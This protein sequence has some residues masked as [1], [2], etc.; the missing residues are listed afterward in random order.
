MNSI[1]SFIRH[2]L[3]E[4]D[5]NY[6]VDGTVQGGIVSSLKDD[7]TENT[8]DDAVSAGIIAAANT[9][10][11]EMRS[12]IINDVNNVL[13]TEGQV[14]RY[15]S[16]EDE[17]E[18]ARGPEF[19]LKA[20]IS[21]ITEGKFNYPYRTALYVIGHFN[22]E[23]SID[24]DL[25]K[26]EKEAATAAK[27]V[28]N[29]KVPSVKKG[30]TIDD[31]KNIPIKSPQNERRNHNQL[32]LLLE[33]PVGIALALLAGWR[34]IM[35]H[36]AA[37]A[38]GAG[39]AKATKAGSNAAKDLIQG[40]G[41]GAIAKMVRQST[42]KLLNEPE[43]FKQLIN[44]LIKGE[45]KTRALLNPEYWI[46]AA[47]PELKPLTK[48]FTDTINQWWSTVD[49]ELLRV[50]QDN[51]MRSLR[52]NEEKIAG[53]SFEKLDYDKC[54]EIIRVI[55]Y[56]IIRQP[57]GGKV[58]ADVIM[59]RF[60]TLHTYFVDHTDAE[61]RAIAKD[62]SLLMSSYSERMQ[63]TTKTLPKD[64]EGLK[65]GP[66]KVLFSNRT[67]VI[68]L[69]ETMKTIAAFGETCANMLPTQLPVSTWVRIG[70]RGVYAAATTVGV[71]VGGIMLLLVSAVGAALIGKGV[72]TAYEAGFLGFD[73]IPE[74]VT[75]DELRSIFTDIKIRASATQHMQSAIEH[76]PTIWDENDTNTIDT[77][78]ADNMLLELL[79]KPAGYEIENAATEAEKCRAAYAD[80]L[81]AINQD[82]I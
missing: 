72:L 68:A 18:R 46:E 31:D 50:R 10:L 34:S 24:D 33:E 69:H 51:L 77:G 40:G 71:T 19:L 59:H 55:I 23:L 36:G 54:V 27:E 3:L 12:V 8:A 37:E 26:L 41:G 56:D 30:R 78:I 44:D 15:V 39:A 62:I 80:A 61:I 60:A 47:P 57:D 16:N 48:A 2:I 49:V 45:G 35:G 53:T 64:V 6:N 74:K 79:K 21:D 14:G 20:D 43:S 67:N 58:T 76:P 4:A 22:G 7:T 82:T 81:E 38:A 28:K 25:N 17:I 73:Y 9:A 42:Q 32:S 13:I 65:D 66:L 29:I 75:D 70:T 52:G 63:S 11:F 5:S 1:R